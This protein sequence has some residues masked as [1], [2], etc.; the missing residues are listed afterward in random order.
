MLPKVTGSRLAKRNCGQVTPAPSAMPRG[1]RNL[2][3]GLLTVGSA[4]REYQGLT[5]QSGISPSVVRLP[6][7]ICIHTSRITQ[8][9]SLCQNGKKC[10]GLRIFMSHN[11]A[12][13]KFCKKDGYTYMNV[14]KSTPFYNTALYSHICDAVVEPQSDERRDRQEDREELSG[15]IACADRHPNC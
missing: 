9:G 14:H 11:I 2:P 7:D 3:N 5:R 1:I 10:H 8:Q 4:T 13:G 12:S 6:T 15:R